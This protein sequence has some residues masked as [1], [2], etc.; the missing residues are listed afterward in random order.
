MFLAMT[1]SIRHHYCGF[2]LDVPPWQ[3]FLVMINKIIKHY[4][5]SWIGRAIMASIFSHD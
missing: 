5:L 3:I 4:Y 1:N 2:A